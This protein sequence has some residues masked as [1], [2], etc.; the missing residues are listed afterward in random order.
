VKAAPRQKA[1][2]YLHMG[3]QPSKQKKKN[4][5]IQ[6]CSVALSQPDDDSC[7]AKNVA[8]TIV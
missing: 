4:V 7:E 2:P 3:Q 1:I 5:R 8:I 6:K